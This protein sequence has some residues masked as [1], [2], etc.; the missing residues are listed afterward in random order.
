MSPVGELA[1]MGQVVVDKIGRADKA[2]GE[3]RARLLIEARETIAK[4]KATFEAMPEADRA[5]V[6]PAVASLVEML[7]EMDRIIG[8]AQKQAAS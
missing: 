6:S 1:L 5:L 4:I 2:T 3:E 8:G 7:P